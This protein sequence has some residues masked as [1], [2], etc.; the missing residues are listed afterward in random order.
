MSKIKQDISKEDVLTALRGVKDSSGSDVVTA[1][2]ISSII[3]KNNSVGFAIEIDINQAREKEILRQECENAVKLISGVG[4]VTAVLTSASEGILSQTMQRRPELASAAVPIAGNNIP[5]VKN[6]I[7][8]ASGKGGVGKSTVAVHLARSL[9]KAGHKVGL[10]DVDIYGPSVPKMMGLSGKPEVDPK[11]HM[12]PK[13]ASSV[14]TISI[15]YLI[16]ENN[17]VIWRSSMALK[18]MNQL[19]RG[20]VWGEIDYLVVDMPP[21]TGDIQLSMAKNFAVTGAILVSTPQDVALIDVKKAATMFRK[22]GVKIFGLV[23]NMSYFEDDSGKKNYIFGEGGA[24]KFAEEQAIPFLGEIPLKQEIREAGD[25]GK[26][27]KDT[28]VIDDIVQN[29]IK[30]MQSK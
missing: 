1:G 12:I 22:V 16:D 17:A 7:L 5:G 18:A 15:G 4:R 28:A 23:E 8:V 9:A 19:M 21:G 14:K 2:I 25:A 3:I 27:L 13:E 30:E 24:R 20:V 6:I 29:L 11:N 10:V 26:A